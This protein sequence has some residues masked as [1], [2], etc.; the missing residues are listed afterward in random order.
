[1]AFVDPETSFNRIGHLNIERN[2]I[3]PLSFLSGTPVKN[4]Y[5]V[6]EAGLPNKLAPT[7]SPIPEDSEF[8]SSGYDSSDKV[9]RPSH[10]VIFTKRAT[11]IIVKHEDILL[12][13]DFTSTA[14]YEGEIGVI[15]GKPGFCIREQDAWE[16]V[17]G[18]TI[19]N[20]V[21]AR[22]RQRDHKQFFIGKSADTYCPIGPIA[23]PKEELPKTLRIQTHVNGELRQDSTTKDLI[24]SIPELLAETYWPPE[25]L[26]VWAS[27]SSLQ[28]FLK[29]ADEISISVTGLGTL[30]NKVSQPGVSNATTHCVSTTSAFELTNASRAAGKGADLTVINGKSISYKQVGSRRENMVFIHGLDFEGHGLSPTHPLSRLTIESLTTDLAGVFRTADVSTSQPATLFAQSMGCLVAMKFALQNPSLVR[31][32]VLISPPPYPLP[33]TRRNALFAH[34]GIAR[35]RGMPAVVEEIDPEG[36]TKACHAFAS[37]NGRLE[38]ESV[39]A[40]T[41]IITGEDDEL[42]TPAVCREY[43]NVIK[44]SRLVVLRNVGHWPNFEDPVGAAEAVKEALLR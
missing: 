37:A 21:T 42:S 4:L 5:Q 29:P 6:I 7:G 32:L 35:T 12:H 10:P 38:L 33:E 18:Y 15:I 25:L 11:S 20:D 28:Y 24:F 34:S 8:N 31:R 27:E 26:P 22:E 3:Q 40:D 23:V 30:T 13:E 41:L 14:D 2:T 19:I 44:G 43:R 16:Y 17:W 39:Q 36:Y 1:M 9:D